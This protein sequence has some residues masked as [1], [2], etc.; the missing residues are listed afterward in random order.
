PES[1]DDI[2]LSRGPRFTKEEESARPPHPPPA[3]LLPRPAPGQSHVI[4]WRAAPTANEPARPPVA[5][6]WGSRA[7]DCRYCR[8][9]GTA[10]RLYRER[11]SW[12]SRPCG[13][14]A[15]HTPHTGPGSS[16]P[17]HRWHAGT[18][19]SPRPWL[20]LGPWA[21]AAAPPASIPV[22]PPAAQT[23]A[24]WRAWCL[25]LFPAGYR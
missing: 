8:T 24:T 20:R 13:H 12:S 17:H 14:P 1:I 25:R 22:R 19:A 6:P 16:V 10:P 18:A 7:C 23:A 3:P 4:T 21:V 9:P 15:A 11:R 5:A 2:S